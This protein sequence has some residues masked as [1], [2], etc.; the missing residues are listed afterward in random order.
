MSDRFSCC[1]TY[2]AAT[3]TLFNSKGL[4]YDDVSSSFYTEFQAA[5]HNSGFY[6]RVKVILYNFFE[7]SASENL[8]KYLI[9]ENQ[10]KPW[11]SKYVP[12]IHEVSDRVELQTAE[13]S[14]VGFRSSNVCMSPLPG[15]STVSGLWI[16]PKNASRS[17]FVLPHAAS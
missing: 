15:Q 6:V 10:H 17:W 9:E 2:S 13:A 8:W 4:E 12:L 7:E 3:R 5:L 1:V 11:G 14:L 16:I